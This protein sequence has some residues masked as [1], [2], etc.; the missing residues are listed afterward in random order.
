MR[1]VQTI[2]GA[3]QSYGGTS[4]SVPGLCDA[5]AARELEVHLVV[6]VPQSKKVLC[7]FPKNQTSVHRVR[8][9]RV[10]GSS[11]Y[12]ELRNLIFGQSDCLVHDHGLWLAS[13]HAVA[14]ITKR[15]GTYRIVSPR[16]MLSKWS[17][18]RRSVVKKIAWS[19][20][21][22]RDLETAD[23]F[24]ATSL[25]EEKDIRRLGYFQPILVAPNAIELPAMLPAR[26]RM[27]PKRIL[28]LSR[29]H[30]VKGLINLVQAFGR[31]ELG[32]EWQLV[33]A[34]PDEVGHRREVEKVVRESL[35]ESR[36]TFTGAVDDKEKWQMYADAD[37][38]VMPSFSENFG[39]SIA[40]AM[41]AG[42]PVITTTATPWESL[43]VNGIGWWVEPNVD[44]ICG[45]IREA[46]SITDL[47]RKNMGMR[48]SDFV[49]RS[50]SW[51]QVAAKFAEF[52]QSAIRN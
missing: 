31:S 11:F 28:F 2:A 48:A 3:R 24:H 27:S 25:D 33:I 32:N 40:E 51:P 20:Y 44:A 45:S 26:L 7:N 38:F 49:R 19:L 12:H 39:L 18:N 23:A 21:Q 17:L 22:Q 35:L 5:L 30:P 15:T 4:R 34:G 47:A 9:S 16:G 13:N 52:Y 6:G 36:V 41:Y 46:C 43:K 10:F 37:I 50:F 42:L 1:I 8:E 14:K 29:I